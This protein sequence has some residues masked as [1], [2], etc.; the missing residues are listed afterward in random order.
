VKQLIKKLI[1][2]EGR[3]V[4]RLRGGLAKGMLMDLDLQSQSQTLLGIR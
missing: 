4:R 1:V 2:P 3:K